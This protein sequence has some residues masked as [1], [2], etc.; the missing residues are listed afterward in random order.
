MMSLTERY[1]DGADVR[2]LQ[3]LRVLLAGTDRRFNRVTSFLL[4]RRGYDVAQTTPPDT[5]AAAEHH[6]SDVVLLDMGD[7]RVSTGRKVAALQALSVVPSIIVV[8]ESG[9]D[10][11]W[12][13]VSA[14]RKWSPIDELVDAIETAAL[15]RPT[16]FAADGASQ[17]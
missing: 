15:T 17:L 12:N 8:F 2:R 11:Q 5:V 6:R 9:D 13:G 10:E 4:S 16:P 7:S 14:I 3:P 1:A